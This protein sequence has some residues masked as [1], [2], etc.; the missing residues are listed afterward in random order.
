M[1][2][3]LLAFVLIAGPLCAQEPAAARKRPPVEEEEESRPAVKPEANR[4]AGPLAN[5]AEAAKKAEHPE[6][7]RLLGEF[8]QPHDILVLTGGKSLN[9]LPLAKRFDPAGE[10][11]VSYQPF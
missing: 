6:L 1:L 11:G 9:V 2:R 3:F 8:V 10:R 7:K 5:L 4:P